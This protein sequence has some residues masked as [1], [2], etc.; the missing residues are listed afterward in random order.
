MGGLSRNNQ[1]L[2][3]KERCEYAG[4]VKACLVKWNNVPEEVSLVL[5]RIAIDQKAKEALAD[6]EGYGSGIF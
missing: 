5:L 2:P 1:S 3:D 4:L 6:G